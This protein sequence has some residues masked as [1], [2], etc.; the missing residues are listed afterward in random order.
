MARKNWK[1]AADRE[2][3]SMSKEWQ[4]DWSDLRKRVM[5]R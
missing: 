2:F 4:D 3:K 5:D 1:K